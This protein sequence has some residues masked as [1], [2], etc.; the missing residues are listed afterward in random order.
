MRK[1]IDIESLRKYYGELLN[2]KQFLE[3]KIDKDQRFISQTHCDLGTEQFLYYKEEITRN[4]KELK[5][6]T[7]KINKT[8]TRIQDYENN[9]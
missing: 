6:V 2:D 3:F 4:Q 5:E 8:K 7:E 1:R 9:R